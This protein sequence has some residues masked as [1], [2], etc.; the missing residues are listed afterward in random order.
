MVALDQHC[1][2]LGG[3]GAFVGIMHGGGGT[4]LSAVKPCGM[5]VTPKKA[6]GMYGSPHLTI[7]YLLRSEQNHRG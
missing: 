5:D 4:L 3:H 2:D 7:S 6:L 1:G